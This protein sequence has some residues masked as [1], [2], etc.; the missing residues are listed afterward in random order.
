MRKFGCDV[1]VRTP[2]Q[3]LGEGEGRM[4]LFVEGEKFKL[5][6]LSSRTSFAA[7]PTP[8][9]TELV[10]AVFFYPQPWF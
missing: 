1:S 10:P 5:L 7:A 4:G 6:N 3:T 2:T 8:N 9:I